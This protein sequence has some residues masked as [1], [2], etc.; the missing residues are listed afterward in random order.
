MGVS[1]FFSIQKK[2]MIFFSNFKMEDKENIYMFTTYTETM[3][4][5]NRVWNATTVAISLQYSSATDRHLIQAMADRQK[6]RKTD[7]QRHTH[8]PT[9]RETSETDRVTNSGWCH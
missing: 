4:E 8:I 7:R 3:K 9:D 2:A 6:Y 5:W 1:G